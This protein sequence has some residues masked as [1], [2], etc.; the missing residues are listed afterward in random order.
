MTKKQK[1]LKYLLAKAVIAGEEINKELKIYK[2]KC[3][4]WDAQI[5]E[6]T[7]II[8][9]QEAIHKGKFKTISVNI[10]LMF[11]TCIKLIALTIKIKLNTN[12]MK[13]QY[14]ILKMKM[15]KIIMVTINKIC[16]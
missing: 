12:I 1:M 8:C 7:D 13:S 16:K 14:Y 11:S 6:Y 4:I 9:E 5:E 10:P 3:D 15:Y 2:D